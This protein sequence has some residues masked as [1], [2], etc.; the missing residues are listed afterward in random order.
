MK[1]LM[2]GWEFPPFKTGGLGTACYG[3]T[4]GLKNMGVEVAFVIPRSGDVETSE[5]VKLIGATGTHK[6]QSKTEEYSHVKLVRVDVSLQPY[7]RPEDHFGVH[8]TRHQ[9]ISRMQVSDSEETDS[10]KPDKSAE[11]YGED[12]FT[13]VQRYAA[14]AGAIARDETFDVIHAHDWMTYQAGMAA[15]K[16]SGK[17]LVVHVH[18]TEYDR[19]G[20]H[21]VNPVIRDIEQMGA[22]AAHRVIAVSKRTKQTLMR[23]Y[24]VSTRKISVV[25]N[26]INANEHAPDILAKRYLKKK[27]VLFLGRITIQ[28][29]PEYFLEAASK[30]AEEEPNVLFVMAG[31][32]D[33]MYKMVERA[34]DLN[35]GHKVLFPGFLKGAALNRIYDMADVY[36]MP[37]VSEPFGIVPLEAMSHGV[38]T[39]ISK[40]SGV[41]EV[42][43]NALKVDF[44]DI[45][46]LANGMV[47]LLRYGALW[48]SLRRN[49]SS[50]M[51]RL[52]W[53]N[54]AS[55]CVGVYQKVSGK[56]SPPRGTTPPMI[57]YPRRVKILSPEV[58]VT[59]GDL[60]P[61]AAGSPT[62]SRQYA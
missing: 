35:I 49:G 9:E 62:A 7:A 27:I 52:S 28:K 43:N 24:G 50:E 58:S 15:S 16:A 30:V 25:H 36:V 47:A 33:M 39:I 6:F 12:L 51:G 53:D 34:S 13:N 14:K 23:Y 2:F 4:K 55:Q 38:P 18:A 17:P 56:I 48:N 19:T 46:G 11:L 26:A 45:D 59:S 32:G 22:R 31:S 40:Q 61:P 3:L 54:S 1:V 10:E 60:N 8:I 42:V 5:H 44:W 29:G 57:E 41:S 37:S 20:G 21:G